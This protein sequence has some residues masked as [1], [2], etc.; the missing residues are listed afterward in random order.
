MKHCPLCGRHY[1]DEA[2]VCDTDRAILRV[3]EK[4]DPYLGN[5]IKGRY[6][7]LT[8][9]GEGGM[10]TV[11]LAEQVSVGRKVAI[12]VLLGNYASDDEFIGRFRR[13]ARLAA[14]LNHRNIVVLYDFDQ[15]ADGSLFIVM[16]YLN[17]EKLSDIIRRNGPL[18]VARATRLGLQIAEG[19]NAAHVAG[20]IHRDIKPDNIMVAGTGNSEEVKLMDFG[21]ARLRDTGK[22]SQITRAGLIVGTP[23]YMAPEQVEGGDVSDK[24]DIYALGVVLYEMLTGNV[25]FKAA[26]PGAVLIKHLKERPLSL[27]KL[28]RELPVAV[29][30][31]VM[32]A[33]EKEPQK[34]QHAM[35]DIVQQLQTAREQLR[36]KPGSLERL[37]YALRK[38]ENKKA[39]KPEISSAQIPAEFADSR[40]ILDMPGPQWAPTQAIPS[41]EV[42]QQNRHGSAARRIISIGLAVLGVMTALGAAAYLGNGW[43]SS[44]RSETAE[45][46]TPAPP[47]EIVSLV[48]GSDKNNL[49]PQEQTRFYASGRLS[50]GR[51]EDV[52]GKVT[53]RSSNSSV[54][55]VNSAGQ[56]QAQNEGVTEV[57]AEMKEKVSAPIT[58]VVKAERPFVNT[59]VRASD[60]RV[61]SLI[62]ISPKRELQPNERTVLTATG[63]QSD[64]KEMQI[65]DGITWQSSDERIASVDGKGRLVAHSSGQVRLNASFQGVTS[66]AIS[67]VVKEPTWPATIEP[68]I[69]SAPRPTKPETEKSKR[70]DIRENL[71]LASIFYEEG[72]YREAMIE[73]EQAISLD[74]ES[75]IARSY[76]MKVLKAWEAE[77]KVSGASQ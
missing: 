18:D 26:T 66:P 42:Y 46:S 70:N 45:P 17:G 16:E 51:D 30:R 54:A 71:R 5:L 37:G 64:G 6:K 11:Y 59:S 74:P 15:A 60:H 3:T 22:A 53:W 27:R 57:T 39:E 73:L 58:V 38:S 50:D 2:Q 69:S 1:D 77:K 23:E 47:P 41:D 19:L 55:S 9:L 36:E 75:K 65:H 14:S 44:G 8:K 76:R 67:I 62:I 28:R 13:E 32:Q 33:L 52:S 12:K 48:I 40:T 35:E 25:P 10:G 68:Q 20:V 56:L 7:V 34:R 29:E 43:N 72:K 21:I 24:T 4:K 31:V 63:V 49:A 61:Q